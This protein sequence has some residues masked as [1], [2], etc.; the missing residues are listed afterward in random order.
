[1]AKL[2]EIVVP[3]IR[4][5]EKEPDMNA[6]MQTE[7]ASLLK[8]K[9]CTRRAARY[10]LVG[11]PRIQLTDTAAQLKDGPVKENLNKIAGLIDG[12]SSLT[13]D[14][15]HPMYG[16]TEDAK[17]DAVFGI[18]E[19]C[20]EGWK[21]DADNPLS[22]Y[23]AKSPSKRMLDL[24]TVPKGIDI[25]RMDQLPGLAVFDSNEQYCVALA[26]GNQQ[27]KEYQDRRNGKLLEFQVAARF[28]PD[29]RTLHPKNKAPQD[30]FMLINA[31]SVG[32]EVDYLLP[33]I[34]DSAD[35]VLLGVFAKPQEVT[36]EMND[37][38][39]GQIATHIKVSID[40]VDANINLESMSASDDEVYA[41][42]KILCIRDE[43]GND[44]TK[45]LER[46]RTNLERIQDAAKD[47]NQLL[48]FIKANRSWLAPPPPPRDGRGKHVWRAYPHA[49]P[50]NQRAKQAVAGADPCLEAPGL[51][52]QEYWQREATTDPGPTRPNCRCYRQATQDHPRLHRSVP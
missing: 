51:R 47:D 43:T 40:A 12:K 16:K 20:T 15:L 42:L 41:L 9:A 35:I 37:E 23:F 24:G 32:P 18:L 33:R 49:W 3:M 22:I 50:P 48:A 30:V 46:L 21:R 6:L 5:R 45:N 39:N 27:E 1:M 2:G 8:V 44:I 14:L 17:D 28:I 10:A 36:E 25:P 29:R 4:C 38:D 13:I 31:S 52:R 19:S 34:G 11:T 26:I 7:A